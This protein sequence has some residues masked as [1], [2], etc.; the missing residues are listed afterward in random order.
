MT[1][2]KSLK[3]RVRA[4]MAKTGERYTAARSQMLRTAPTETPGTPPE[5]V[6]SPADTSVTGERAVSDEAV[7]SRTGRPWDEWFALLEAWGARDRPHPEIARWLSAEH[8]V[9]SWWAQGLTVRYEKAIGRRR[10]GQ[11]ADGFAITAS[12]TVG[13]PVER[14]FAAFVDDE[15]RARWLPGASLSVRTSTPHR[16][17]RF[18]WEDGSSR[19]VVG[20]IPKDDGRSSVA[21]EHQR[22]PDPEAAERLRGFWRER[23][24]EL[25]RVLES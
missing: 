18:D 10:L 22:L 7:A 12:K 24:R 15:L 5:T 25:Q 2:K 20:F 14:L 23:L 4:R 11:R 8:G 1:E 3:R 17:A 9:D 6:D 21:L 16:S 19:L 13:V